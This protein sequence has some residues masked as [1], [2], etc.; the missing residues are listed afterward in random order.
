MPELPPQA[1]SADSRRP[2]IRGGRRA[3]TLLEILLVLALMGLLT[4]VLVVGANRMLATPPVTAEGAFWQMVAEARRYAL[5]HEINVQMTFDEMST[6]L[7]ATAEDG[8]ILPA[9]VAPTG[10][11]FTFQPGLT[12]PT[13]TS[14]LGGTA[15]LDTPLTMIT[16]YS[17]GTCTLFRLQVETGGFGTGAP[18]TVQIDPWTCAPLFLASGT[19]STGGF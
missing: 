2:A 13:S 16:F 4:S 6:S 14:G 5:Q 7:M 3:F 19:T 12:A 18:Q 9:V 10:S 11:K 17:D 1:A 8:T 15:L